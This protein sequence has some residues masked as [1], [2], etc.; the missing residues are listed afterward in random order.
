MTPT[1]LLRDGKVVLVT[2]SPGGSRIISTVV[3]VIANVVD[4]RMS[5][6]EAVA[7]PRL[8]HQW[9]PDE[10]SAEP[11]VPPDLL[12]RLESRGHM[13]ARSGR[14]WSSANSIL[15]TPDGL[16]GGADPRTRGALAAGF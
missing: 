9:M 10:V 2:G 13:V 6:A 1:F 7:A 4:R 15:V 14:P 12:A 11:A 5:I 8:H 3:Q 16:A